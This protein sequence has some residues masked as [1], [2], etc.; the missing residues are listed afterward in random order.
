LSLLKRNVWKVPDFG[1]ILCNPPPSVPNQIFPCSSSVIDNTFLLPSSC[2]LCYVFDMLKSDDS[3][4]N[5]L[6]SMPIQWSP[7]EALWILLIGPSIEICV[8][9]SILFRRGLAI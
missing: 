6:W 1:W 5:P 7:F 2:S 3:C 4:D 9:D 8:F